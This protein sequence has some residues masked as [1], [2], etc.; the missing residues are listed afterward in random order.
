[1][2]VSGERLLE[3]D[4]DECSPRGTHSPRRSVDGGDPETGAEDVEVLEDDA[5]LGRGGHF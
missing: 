1:M 4:A 5:R 2:A 3:K